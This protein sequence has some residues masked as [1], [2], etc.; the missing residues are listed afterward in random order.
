MWTMAARVSIKTWTGPAPAWYFSIFHKDVNL[1]Y[2]S[3][4][5]I[6]KSRPNPCREI[7]PLP[8]KLGKYRVHLL[9]HRE[10]PFLLLDQ[11]SGD[12]Y[13]WKLEASFPKLREKANVKMLLSLSSMTR[14]L[15][16]FYYLL[17]FSCIWM[18]DFNLFR[19]EERALETTSRKWTSVC[20]QFS[21]QFHFTH[22]TTL[23][24]TNWGTKLVVK[25]IPFDGTICI[26]YTFPSTIH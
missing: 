19:E 18:M 23:L 15:K 22:A 24:C 12:I 7:L 1:F 21:R 3:R 13:L 14:T 10:Q 5:P 11:S 4:I 8:P 26:K 9:F 25:K 6:L 20:V 2:T 16:G 17:L